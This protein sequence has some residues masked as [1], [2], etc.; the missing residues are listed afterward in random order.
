MKRILAI[1]CILVFLCGCAPQKTEAA[2]EPAT[3]PVTEPEVT[4]PPAV[5]SEAVALVE[6]P[7]PPVSVVLHPEP[8]GEKQTQ[9]ED[10]VIDYSHGEDG[11]IMARYTGQTE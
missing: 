2:T 4:M 3:A 6:A 7:P 10:A 1:L 5:A 9:C 11:Y 8:S